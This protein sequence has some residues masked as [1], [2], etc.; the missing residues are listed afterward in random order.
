M[1]NLCSNYIEISGP[2]EQL[3]ALCKRILDQEPNLINLIPNFT[4][5]EASDYS[6]Y[7]RDEITIEGD[8]LCFSFGSKYVSPLDEIT[9]LSEEYPDLEFS[10]RFDEGG[11]DYYGTAGIMNGGCSENEMEEVDY[12]EAFHVDYIDQRDTMLAMPYDEFLKQ[13]TH[14]NFFDEYPFGYIDRH[15]VKRIKDNDL[16]KFINRQ[17][18]DDDAEAEYKQRLS[19]GSKKEA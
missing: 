7:H 1:A 9:E 19:G 10:L 16:A 12:I 13:Y 6:I 8:M 3:E 4:I 11:N 5:Q 14:E 18:F 2:L 15:V 17:W